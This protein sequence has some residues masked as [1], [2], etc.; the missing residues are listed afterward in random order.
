[1]SDD[2]RAPGRDPA[3]GGLA[4]RPPRFWVIVGLVVLGAVLVLQNS[5]TIQ[6][7]LLWFE[8]Q[9]PLVILLLAMAFIGAGV[10]RAWQWR[11]NRK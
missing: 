10:D 3:K 6:V 4:G 1:V 9:M 5:Q 7:H 2:E 11:R 8:I